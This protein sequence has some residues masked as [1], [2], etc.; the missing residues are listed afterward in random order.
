M[1]QQSSTLSPVSDSPYLGYGT[2]FNGG[3]NVLAAQYAY[4]T[5]GL[6]TLSAAACKAHC[7]A[8]VSCGSFQ[9]W[10]GAASPQCQLLSAAGPDARSAGTSALAGIS[11][12]A[13]YYKTDFA[14]LVAPIF[15]NQAAK[16]VVV[17]PTP[18]PTPTPA[19]TA[20]AAPPM[21]TVAAPAATTAP[22]SAPAPAP[23][24]VVAS[25]SKRGLSWPWNNPTSSFNLFTPGR[26]SWLYN[27]EMWDPRP[28]YGGWGAAVEYV[29]M[30]RSADRVGQIASYF[31]DAQHCPAHFLALNEPDLPGDTFLS[32]AD[33]VTLWRTCI[34]PLKQRCPGTRISAPAV[35]NGAGANWGFDWL[36]QFFAACPDCKAQTDFYAVHWYGADVAQ[37]E[38]YLQS[39]HAAFGDKPMW[40]TEF[41]YTAITDPNAYAYAAAQ[42][43]TWLD[44]QPYI[45]RYA[46]FGPMDPANMV[47]MPWGAMVTSDLSALTATGRVYNS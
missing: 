43:L 38:G 29:P 20:A 7:D 44:A 37:F 45:E 28:D 26:E 41:A 31:G 6:A 36:G 34:T 14:R 11:N 10:T 42:T 5:I 33:A 15:V 27:W 18:T 9:L 21:T 39:Y 19:T 47:G 3:Q 40:V 46:M 24:P 12:A 4:D 35:T 23:A 13:G 22:A 32:V 30:L 17:A 2:L 16:P 1:G 8:D 25:G